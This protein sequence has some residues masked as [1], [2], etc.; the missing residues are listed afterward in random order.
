MKPIP[1]PV[2]S[3]VIPHRFWM[4]FEMGENWGSAWTLR[5]EAHV[6]GRAVLEVGTGDNYRLGCD[7][8]SSWWWQARDDNG[9]SARGV[10][11][12]REEAMRKAEEAW[13]E[14][15]LDR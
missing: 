13:L 3:T 2:L 1:I 14:M 7:A 10:A 11:E 12:S 6:W 15:E 4:P 8:S 5:P 9:S